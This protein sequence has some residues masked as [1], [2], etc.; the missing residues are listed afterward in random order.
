MKEAIAKFYSIK[1][2]TEENNIRKKNQSQIQD[3]LVC[4]ERAREAE[5]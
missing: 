3:R 1:L 2:F 4:L 5:Y